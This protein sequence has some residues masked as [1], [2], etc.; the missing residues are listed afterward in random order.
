MSAEKLLIIESYELFRQI[1][2]NNK[3]R[4]AAMFGVSPSMIEKMWKEPAS[5]ENQNATGAPNPIER[6]DALIDFCLV[7][8]PELAQA[9]VS[10]F[11]AKIDEHHLKNIRKP[12]SPEEWAKKIGQCS[13]E[14]GEAL[15]AIIE[16]ANSQ[17]VRKEWEDLKVIGEE[18]VRR[19]EAGETHQVS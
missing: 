16:G 2:K 12:L 5:D 10:R 11:Q 19:K 4:L 13:R 14:S 8:C 7:Y 3:Q 9:L 17:D 18:I 6:M 15:A 1:A